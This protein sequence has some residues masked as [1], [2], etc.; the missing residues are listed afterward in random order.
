MSVVDIDSEV[1]TIVQHIETVRVQKRERLR[2]LDFF[3]LDNSIRE[4]TVGQ[5]RSHTL[6]NKI[7]ILHQVRKC[8]I[9]DIIVATFAHLTRVDDDFVEHLRK[10]KEDFSHFYSFS[11]VSEGFVK[12]TGVYDTERVPVGLQ[13]NKKYGLINTIF[14]VDLADSSCNW[15]KF[16]VSDMCNLLVKW[17]NYVFDE[18]SPDGKVLLN[19][20]DFP[21]AMSKYPKRAL[22]IVRFL[23]SLPKGRRMFGL[24]FEDPMGEYLPEELEAWT[25]SVRRI[26]VSCGWPEGRLLV[27]IHQKWD[28]Q[29]ASQLDCLGAGADGVWASLCEEGAALGHASSAVTMMNLVRLGNTKILQKYNCTQ[30]RNAAMAVTKLTTGK[31]PHPKQVV[32]GERAVDLVLGSAGVG[33][34]DLAEFFGVETPNRITTLATVEMIKDRLVNLFGDHEQFN[35]E[36]CSKMKEQMLLDLRS[37]KKEEYHSPAGIALLFDKAGGKMTPEMGKVVANLND[38]LAHHQGLIDEI[39]KEWDHWDDQ[40]EGIDKG[41]GMLLFD[42]FYHGFM[43]PYFG[44]YRCDRTKKAMKALDMDQDGYVDWYEFLVYIKWALCQY[45]ETTDPDVLLSIAFEEGLI[46]AMRDEKIIKERL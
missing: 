11:E 20:R 46:P 32:Y 31:P 41:D 7:D 4:S 38:N 8:G 6:Q 33:D 34:F 2:N 30:L 9:K 44:C 10:E 19:F 18:I 37:G 5:L 28:L 14:E 45:P 40:E 13:K 36:L 26:M 15:D 43:A 39:R 21:I 23:S 3:C 16:T 27:H 12:G 42:S 24:L 17:M 25:T 35:D 29:T 22:L 1:S